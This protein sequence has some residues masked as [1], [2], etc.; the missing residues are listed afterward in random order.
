M[1]CVLM[2]C[3]RILALALALGAAGC[4]STGH[5]SLHQSA[6]GGRF[7]VHARDRAT[8]ERVLSE[9]KAL[10]LGVLAG[11]TCGAP[12]AVE[13]YCMPVRTRYGEGRNLTAGDPELRHVSSI[14]IDIGKEYAWERFVIAHELTHTW[15]AAEWNPLPQ[16]LEE[17]L[18][19]MAG[20]RADP[21][22][23]TCR[24]LFHGL[25]LLTWAGIGYPFWVP[26]EGKRVG[27][28]VRMGK[29]EQGLPSLAQML[30]LDGTSYHDVGGEQNENLLYAVG[31]ELAREIGD[32][33]LR[34][35]CAR[36]RDL[37]YA[38][39]P[40][41]WVLAAAE[42]T[43][44]TDSLWGVRGNRLIHLPEER[45]LQNCLLDQGPFRFGQD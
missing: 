43:R 28:M 15:L 38:Q 13:I 26:R 42:L 25:R 29:L 4:S 12:F 45:M 5:D 14:E 27:A 34:D 7:T 3:A 39:I 20:E 24:R 44:A 6:Q 2:H 17:G 35:L 9:C 32:A 37:G 21:E 10:E 19:D 1:L 11:P 31:Y 33:K 40:A 18:C 8:A 36:A 30:E 23:G 22:A 41:D 16:I